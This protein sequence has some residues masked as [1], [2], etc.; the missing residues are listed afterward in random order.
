MNNDDQK[1]S[2]IAIKYFNV[3]TMLNFMYETK[4][5]KNQIL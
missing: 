1:Q 5:V 3:T 4:T 2:E